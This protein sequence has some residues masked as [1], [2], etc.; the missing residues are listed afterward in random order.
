MLDS[1][2]SNLLTHDFQL[3]GVRLRQPHTLMRWL[4]A[5]AAAISTNSGYNEILD[6][7]TAGEGAKPAAKT[8]IAYRE[9]LG[10]LWLLE[11]LP[12]WIEGENFF[13]GL[14]MTPKHYLIDPAFAVHLL[15]L[16]E[17][18]LAAPGEADS[19]YAVF[20][21]KYGS[22][23]GRLFEALVFLDLKVYSGVNDADLSYVATAKNDHEIDF[24]VSKA[25]RAVAF[26]V[27]LAP[28]IEESDVRHLLW[29][30]EK[31]AGRIRDAV[32]ITTGPYAY[33][34]ED[35]IAVVPAALLGA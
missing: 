19:D 4:R 23:I 8:T 28:Y 21:R 33:R 29:L 5:Y 2:F 13:S 9:A 12:V 32:V 35:G 30:K 15:G 34:R 24:V 31:A 11:E 14:K 18:M 6:A 25:R 10:N 20:D 7:S 3:Q 27:K 22:I 17:D 26:E 16:D 1:Y